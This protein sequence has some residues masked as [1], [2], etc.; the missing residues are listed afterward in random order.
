MP[1][2]SREII[3]FC[4]SY[5]ASSP[6]LTIFWIRLTLRPPPLQPLHSSAI[7]TYRGSVRG[8]SRKIGSPSIPRLGMYC[9]TRVAQHAAPG[10]VTRQLHQSSRYRTCTSSSGPGMSH[11]R[12]CIFTILPSILWSRSLA[13]RSRFARILETVS[14]NENS[15]MGTF[16]PA[17]APGWS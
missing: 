5:S 3:L 16:M 7:L 17:G 4:A 14:T 1:P 8:T 10:R 13:T 11:P 9:N 12:P 15:G 6:G 2:T